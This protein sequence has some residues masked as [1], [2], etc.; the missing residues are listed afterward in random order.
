[1]AVIKLNIFTFFSNMVGSFFEVM[2]TMYSNVLSYEEIK[3]VI[4]D[5]WVMSKAWRNVT[6]KAPTIQAGITSA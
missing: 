2:Y 3:V 6:E 5:C 1:M 4:K